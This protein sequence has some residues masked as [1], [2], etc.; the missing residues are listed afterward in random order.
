MLT[1]NVHWAFCCSVCGGILVIGALS[2]PALAQETSTGVA[3]SQPADESAYWL[4]VSA[5]LLNV[6]SRPD[7]NS[8][9]VTRVREGTLLR[10]ARQVYGWHEVEPPEG[11]FCLVS[12]EYIDRRGEEQGVVSVRSGRLRVRVGSTVHKLD[13][14]R[15]EV[16]A[17]LESGTRVRIVSEVD[18]WLKIAPPEG[19]RAYVSADHV[20]RIS[21]KVAATLRDAAVEAPDTTLT[22]TQE[23]QATTQPATAVSLRGE[24]GQKLA[25]I[26]TDIEA[27]NR[28]PAL[29][30][31]WSAI[32][33][34]L[35]PITQQPAEPAVGRLA[36]AWITKLDQRI[37][38]QA[39]LRAAEEVLRRNE[40]ERAQHGREM[41][42]VRELRTHAA[43]QPD[44]AAQG[45]LRRSF[46]ANAVDGHRL[47]KLLDPATLDVRAYV[48]A[49]S[50]V[51]LAEYLGR[52]VGV[53]GERQFDAA[54]GTEVIR[55]TAL[56][57]LEAAEPAS[58]TP[59][60]E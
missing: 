27:E 43:T 48:V 46:V 16:Q 30:Q 49:A 18:G 37:S 41:R 13:P 55:V 26:E 44:F 47:Y 10:G 14:L 58:G 2:G 42:R 5:N 24:W 23:S 39:A 45:T 54:L 1:R 32:R 40:R 60:A 28:K 20:A 25:A 33:G 50:G 11:I 29:D 3:A 8:T 57:V 59:T 15:S 6:R 17:L 31:N 9:V 56:R 35:Q 38:E 53:Q 12:A 52:Y 34:R 51:D 19:V 7:G 36:A 21:D 22:A 4:R